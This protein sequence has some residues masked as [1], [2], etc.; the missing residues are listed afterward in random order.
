LLPLSVLA[1]RYV[2]LEKI[3]QGGMAAIYRAQ[4][5]RL[6]GRVV[7]IKEM[8]ES[9]IPEE[10]RE[11]VLKAFQ[12]EA[13]LLARFS[14]PNIVRV[15]DRFQEQDRHYMVMEFIQGKTLEQLLEQQDEP[16]PEEQVLIWAEQLCDALAYLH[17]R[18]PKV[19][20]RDLKPANVMVVDGTDTVKLIDFG[21]ARFFKPGQSKDT[22]QFGT[23]GYAPPEQY[24]K[25]QTDERA[26]IYSLGALLHHLLSLRDP[27]PT[28][29]DF[30]P[31][32]QLN[33]KVSPRVEKAI[34]RAVEKE[35]NKRFSSIKEMWNALRGEQPS[36]SRGPVASRAPAPKVRAGAGFNVSPKTLDWGNVVVGSDVPP[37]FLKVTLPSGVK[38]TVSAD[39][40]WLAI[41]PVSLDREHNDVI[42]RLVTY[43]LP[44]GHLQISGDGLKLWA[45]W[46]TRRLVPAPNSVHGSIT[47]ATD[48]GEQE[49]V[50][51]ALTAVPSGGAV[52][53]GCLLALF[54]MG[55]ELAACLLL[56]YVLLS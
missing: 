32:C 51:V 35:R 55:L 49:T 9:V 43:Q 2:I 54:L 26:D 33:P 42:V 18:N 15:M 50:S 12:R 38:A 25:A 47:I 45:G 27:T 36:P 39:V 17:S 10:E 52:L 16:F 29:F 56:I 48:D 23:S 31:L 53:G 1:G 13:Q 11:A 8:S 3:A 41:H 19:I 14:H 28:L 5:K 34:A 44:L 40:P 37:L 21:I 30:P 4:D 20:Y 22:I 7:A 24:G 46:H 6:R